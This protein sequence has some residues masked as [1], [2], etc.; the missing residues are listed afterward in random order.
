MGLLGTT[1]EQSYYSQSQT[2]TGDGSGSSGTV[3]FTLATTSFP[4]LPTAETQFDV[5]INNI[6]ISSSN[7]RTKKSFTI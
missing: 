1:T 4:T 3:A 5:F 7:S 2:F 6:Q